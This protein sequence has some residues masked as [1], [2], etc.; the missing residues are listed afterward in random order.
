VGKK[1]LLA[2]VLRWLKEAMQAAEADPGDGDGTTTALSYRELR[3]DIA[4]ETGG[5]SAV[6]VRTRN[7]NFSGCGWRT[8]RALTKE[9]VVVKWEEELGVPTG[10]D[11]LPQEFID[12]MRGEHDKA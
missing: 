9:G 11:W 5:V 12:W 10:A 8:H 7:S 1:V 6:F 3:A 4:I 2:D